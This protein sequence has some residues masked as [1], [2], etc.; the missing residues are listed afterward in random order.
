MTVWM[1][2]ERVRFVANILPRGSRLNTRLEEMEETR[3][4]VGR[5]PVTFTQGAIRTGALF[6]FNDLL[7]IA[8]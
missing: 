4:C 3:L 1:D 5:G 8:T 2:Q 7:I 6:L